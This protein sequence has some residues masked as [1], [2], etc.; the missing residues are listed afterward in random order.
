MIIEQNIFSLHEIAKNESYQIVNIQCFP[1][2]SILL[3]VGNTQVDYFSVDVEG[4]EL[5]VLTSIPWHKVNIKVLL[6]LFYF[7]FNFLLV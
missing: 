3:A 2:Y 7:Y 5:Q 1:L 4:S 6:I